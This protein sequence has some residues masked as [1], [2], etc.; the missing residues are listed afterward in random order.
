MLLQGAGEFAG[1]VAGVSLPF[2]E[3]V[4]SAAPLARGSLP[5]A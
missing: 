1:I 5:L 2:Y 3:A 4:G